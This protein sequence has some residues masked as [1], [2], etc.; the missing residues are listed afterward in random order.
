MMHMVIPE[1]SSEA[2]EAA[3]W[4]THHSEIEAEMRRRVKQERL[5]AVTKLKR[6]KADYMEDLAQ[7]VA[8][9]I[10]ERA[11][12]MT[13]DKRAKADSETRKIARTPFRD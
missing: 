4:D 9:E 3:W 1:F 11:A 7:R 6:P 12:K 13:P 2:K 10:N 8:S 5:L